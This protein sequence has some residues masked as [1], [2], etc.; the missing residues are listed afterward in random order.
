ML[1][2]DDPITLIQK[3]ATME[4]MQTVIVFAVVAAPALIAA[5][6]LLRWFEAARHSP[7]IRT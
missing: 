1:R 4:L 3:E 2:V 5:Y 6:I 7:R